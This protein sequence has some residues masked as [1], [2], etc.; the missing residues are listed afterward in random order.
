MAV[1]YWVKS[2]MCECQGNITRMQ[3]AARLPVDY[4]MYMADIKKRNGI[5]GNRLCF[6]L[7]AKNCGAVITIINT[8][9]LRFSRVVPVSVCIFLL[10]LLQ[11]LDRPANR[12]PP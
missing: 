9:S 10:L 12:Q 5:S 6:R 8:K 3:T 4:R 2:L 1:P 11:H 7:D